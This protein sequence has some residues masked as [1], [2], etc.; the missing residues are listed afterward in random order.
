[1]AQFYEVL[2]ILTGVWRLS[3]PKPWTLLKHIHAGRKDHK[4][5]KDLM[6][7][8]HMYLSVSDK[9]HISVHLKIYPGAFM[10]SWLSVCKHLSQ[11]IVIRIPQ[12]RNLPALLSCCLWDRSVGVSPSSETGKFITCVQGVD[13]PKL[14]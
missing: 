7:H 1:M 11:L 6:C 12:S 8:V 10:L 14:L 5:R 2:R 9:I 3:V 13:K 4:T